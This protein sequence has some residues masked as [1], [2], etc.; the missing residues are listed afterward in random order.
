MFEFLTDQNFLN[1]LS[2]AIGP[3]AFFAAPCDEIELLLLSGDMGVD[4]LHAGV[5]DLQSL[6]GDLTVARS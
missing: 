6:E 3:L 1:A 2:L 4:T 5:G